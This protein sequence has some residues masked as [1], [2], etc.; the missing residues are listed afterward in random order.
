MKWYIINKEYVSYLKEFDH[1]IE[2]IDYGNKLRPYIG[3]I[4]EI[5]N[6]KY[7]V[8]ISSPKEKHHRMNNSIDFHKITDPIT[9]H[10][11]G[12]IN[13]NNMFPVPDSE[14]K[15]LRYDKL[16]ELR[17]FDNDKDRNSYTR[18][19]R[20]ELNIIN[21]I[22]D[23]LKNKAAKLYNKVINHQDEHLIN[24]CCNFSLLEEK[25]IA[26]KDNEDYKKWPTHV[27]SIYVHKRRYLL[28]RW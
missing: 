28:C 19:L 26:Y 20:K 14:I 22:E 25:C 7:Y 6:I 1:K 18:L 5:N 17:R 23:K 12:V 2:N 11:Y 21:G 24:R 27:R 8:P 15:I 4:M 16:H 10:L 3:I 9:N 13:L